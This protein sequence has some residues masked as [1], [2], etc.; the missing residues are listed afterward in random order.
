MINR[1][2]LAA[3]LGVSVPTIS[4][5]LG[6]LETTRQIIL[7]PPFFENFGTRIVKSPRLYFADSGL[8]CHLL[9]IGSRR[10]LERSPFH[11][12]VFESF[13]VSEIVKHQ[14]NRGRRSEVYY[15]RDRQGLEVDLLVPLGGN[16][17]LLAEL[18]AGKTVFPGD[19]APLVRLRK[20]MK[21]HETESLIVYQP[22]GGRPGQVVVQPGVRGTDAKGLLQLLD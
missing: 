10:E 13:V 1:A 3:G 22:S 15:F 14:V 11:G 20:S 5:W 12:A 6:I 2:D 4:Q 9:G 16:R 17:V 7:V 18:K 21:R 19:A 8:L